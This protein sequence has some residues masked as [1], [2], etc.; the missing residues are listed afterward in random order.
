[1]SLSRQRDHAELHWAR[2]EFGTRA[3]LDRTLCRDKP[4]ELALEEFDDRKVTLAEVLRD[5]SRFALL[6]P[7]R[8]RELLHEYDAKT[9][10]LG[11]VRQPMY[12]WYDELVK[13]PQVETAITRVIE[14]DALTDKARKAYQEHQQLSWWDKLQA[15]VSERELGRRIEEAYATQVA[16]ERELAKLRSDP[17]LKEQV[18]EEIKQ[19]NRR[20]SERTQRVFSGGL[21]RSHPAAAL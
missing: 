9:A 11:V 2:E 19:R 14:A 16:A 1:V 21:R 17:G 20:I 6:A 12:D 8:Q 7:Q 13:L 18:V 5:D 10:A 4:K 3:E 15:G